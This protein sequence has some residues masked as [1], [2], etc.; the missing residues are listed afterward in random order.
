MGVTGLKQNA[1]GQKKVINNLEKTVTEL[2]SHVDSLTE[3]NNMLA[4][5]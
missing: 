1:E 4:N 2:N 5:K 3:K